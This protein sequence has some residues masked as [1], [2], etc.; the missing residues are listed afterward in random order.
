MVCLVWMAVVGA[1]LLTLTMTV[2]QR[3]NEEVKAKQ[4]LNTL[5]RQKVRLILIEPHYDRTGSVARGVSDD[6]SVVAGHSLNA[7]GSD[8][9]QWDQNTERAFRWTPGIETQDLGSFGLERTGINAI[10]GDGRVIVWHVYVDSYA[11][12]PFRW[13]A[14]TGKCNCST[15]YP[16]TFRYFGRYIYGTSNK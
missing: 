1:L 10:F 8:P 5:D 12:R 4:R 3:I 11:W 14:E 2:G 9:Q 15:S 16:L 6:G 13:I 7:Q